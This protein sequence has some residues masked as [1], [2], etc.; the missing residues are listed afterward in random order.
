MPNRLALF[1]FDGTVTEKDSFI[2]FIKYYKGLRSF[3]SGIILMSPLLILF[4]AGV[5]KNWRVKELVFN[6]FFRNEKIDF[7]AD[8][9]RRFG[10]TRIP[11][12]VKPEAMELI[13]GHIKSGNRVIIVTAT[14]ENI[15]LD[16]CNA[17][18]LELIGTK[19]EVKNGL[20]TGKFDGKNCYGSE[21][22]KRLNQ[23]LD[24]S[25]FSEIYA[26]GDSKS[27]NPLMELADHKY[28]RSL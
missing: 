9:C 14:F 21:K 12:L 10:I 23:Y 16:W 8:R 2:E 19:I 20:I 7:F 13:D 27:D 17:Q 4:R 15:L 22:V 6:F 5:V 3:Y 1:D 24:I 11:E 18:H 26:Y 28:Y 25:Q